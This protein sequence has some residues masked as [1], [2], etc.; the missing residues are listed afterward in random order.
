MAEHPSLEQMIAEVKR[1]IAL[2]ANVY[3]R[4]KPKD[5]DEHMRRM[6]GV[7]RT[8]EWLNGKAAPNVPRPADLVAALVHVSRIVDDALKGL[9]IDDIK[10]LA[11]LLDRQMNR[12]PKE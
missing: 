12:P 1:E 4:K 6:E 10:Q 8:L 11:D 2:R 3:K 9:P 7:L 5:G